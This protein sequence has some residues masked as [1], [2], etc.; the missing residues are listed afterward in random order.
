M[1]LPKSIETLLEKMI[2]YMVVI[3]TPDG[4]IPNIGDSDDG[5]GFKFSGSGDF[6]DMRDTISS[7]S[8]L[9]ENGEMKCVSRKC[10]EET[11][12]LFGVS[13]FQR[14]LAIKA[15]EPQS[16]Y[17]LLN[18]SGHYVVRSS[19][20]DDADYIFIRAGEFGMGGDGFS[21]HS[22]D[23]LLSP[24][25]YLKGKQIL[26]DSGTFEYNSESSVRNKFKVASAH[27]NISWSGRIA[28]PKPNFGWEMTYNA[29]I[30]NKSIN[31]DGVIAEFGIGK[32]TGYTRVFLYDSEN[33][34]FTI[35]DKFDNDFN[36]LEW[37]FHIP[38]NFIVKSGPESVEI[39][40]NNVVFARLFHNLTN[41]GLIV[42]GSISHYYGKLE[43]GSVVSF[44]SS[45]KKGESIIFKLL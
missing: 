5:R 25:I 39:L 17:G 22:H 1:P 43:K 37:N 28:I 31:Y 34:S 15:T 26:M 3:T 2:G 8:V 13:G 4:R 29:K 6:W 32:I 18:D 27:N 16:L 40:E 9:F 38:G 41:S 19:W 11:F 36:D 12:W 33:R 14:F 7:G 44:K 23:D 10:Y 20:R 35:E 45:I 42:E 30:K 21:S 24:I